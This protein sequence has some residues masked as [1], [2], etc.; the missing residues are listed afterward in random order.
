[1]PTVLVSSLPYLLQGAVNTLWMSAVCVTLG[2]VVGVVIGILSVLA[3]AVIRWMITAYVFVFRGTPVLVLMFLAYFALPAFGLMINVFVAV[4]GA[5]VLYT[6]SFVAEITR[7]AILSIPR[8]QVDAAKS[9]GMRWGLIL[10]QIILPQALKMSLPPLLNNSVI[11]IKATSYAS[12]VGV[13]E[14]TYAAREIVERS[15]AAFQIFLGVMAIYFLI[16]Y[17]LSV[18]ARRLEKG[19]A[20]IH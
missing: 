17:P 19:A 4:G 12:I 18:L 14:L 11:M 2:T 16:C 20:F 7:G 5:L 13:W 3:P 15:L 6:G 8:G 9:L 1:M 10:R